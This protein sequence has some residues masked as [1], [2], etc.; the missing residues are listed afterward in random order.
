MHD[1]WIPEGA[2]R[3]DQVQIPLEAGDYKLYI[4]SGDG[5]VGEEP[6]ISIQVNK[7]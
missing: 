2:M 1:K 5:A 4:V 3:I 6:A 7:Q